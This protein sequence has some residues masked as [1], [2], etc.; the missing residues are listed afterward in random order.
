MFFNK[1]SRLHSMAVKAPVS[2]CTHL[3]PSLSTVKSFQVGGITP[4]LMHK[5]SELAYVIN[6]AV[7]G[8]AV[9]NEGRVP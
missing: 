1:K 6:E 4:T 3:S 9:R 2:I 7:D 8:N 5:R